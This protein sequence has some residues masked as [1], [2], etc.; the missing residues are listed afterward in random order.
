MS[1]AR[2]TKLIADYIMANVEGEPSRDEGVGEC[3]I[4]L[5]AKYRAALAQIMLE[6]GGP[7]AN[8]P[9]PVANAYEIARHALGAP[10]HVTRR[11]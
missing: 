10:A 8:C 5:L 3:A 2:Q 1:A 11:E 6:I 7:G 9:A 4:R